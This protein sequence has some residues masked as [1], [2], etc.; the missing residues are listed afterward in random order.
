[1][2]FLV[3]RNVAT[4]GRERSYRAFSQVEVFSAEGYPVFLTIVRREEM[5]GAWEDLAAGA[6]TLWIQATQ[7]LCLFGP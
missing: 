1:M 7:R 6:A 5:S 3:R 4:V 2:R